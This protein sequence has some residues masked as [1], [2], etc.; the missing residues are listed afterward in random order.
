MS[1]AFSTS[2]TASGSTGTTCSK[3]GPYRSSRNARVTIFVKRGEKFPRDVDGS[4]TTW[5]FLS[6][7]TSIS[8]S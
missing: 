2:I 4:K 7:S 8:A 6:A 5:T 1:D 3:T